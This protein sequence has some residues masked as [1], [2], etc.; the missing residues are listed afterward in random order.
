MA[1]DNGTG[2]D[3]LHSEVDTLQAETTLQ[4]RQRWKALY[5]PEPPPRAAA[6]CWSAVVYRPQER[7]LGG[8]STC[9]MK[10]ARRTVKAEEKRD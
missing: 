3:L 2:S 4:L 8:L 10:E 9:S 5:D 6:I 7:A 1:W